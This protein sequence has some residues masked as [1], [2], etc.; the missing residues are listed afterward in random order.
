MSPQFWNSRSL[1]EGTNGI[2]ANRAFFTGSGTAM[3]L[4]DFY[5]PPSTASM[6]FFPIFEDRPY[7]PG[8]QSDTTIT[9]FAD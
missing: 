3:F 7:N 6:K 2:L 9:T 4:L 5:Q 1:S 8:I